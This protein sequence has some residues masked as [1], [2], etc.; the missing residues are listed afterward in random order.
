M[1]AKRVNV[2][3]VDPGRSGI[4]LVG[5]PAYDDPKL[6]DVPVVAS[7]IADL[8]EVLTDRQSGGF[9]P[10][11]LCPQCSCRQGIDVLVREAVD[12]AVA[13]RAELDDPEQVT[14]LTEQCEADTRALIAEAYRRAGEDPVPAAFTAR[15]VAER[16]GSLYTDYRYECE[17]VVGAVVSCDMVF[18]NLF[19]APLSE[20][21]KYP[22]TY[23]KS[24]LPA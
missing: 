14:A 9:T 7:N 23:S 1:T 24:S 13:V 10:E 19:R 18:V 5:A 2:R 17:E 12:L 22:S 4:L 11:H 6:H 20:P 3:A 8:A 16:V 15:E 21:I